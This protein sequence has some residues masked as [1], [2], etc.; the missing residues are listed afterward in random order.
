MDSKTCIESQPPSLFPVG[1]AAHVH[2]RLERDA[3]LI[4]LTLLEKDH[5][6]EPIIQVPEVDTAHTTF[7]VSRNEQ[8]PNQKIFRV[9]NLRFDL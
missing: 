2:V 4:E 3:F 7:V 6:S 8:V 5:P 9:S 1:V